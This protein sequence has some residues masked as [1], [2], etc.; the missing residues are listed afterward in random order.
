VQA[1]LQSIIGAARDDAVSRTGLSPSAVKVLRAERVT[2]PDGSLGCPSPGMLYTQALVPGFRVMLDAGGQA[3][4]Y[5][6]GASGQLLLCP[7][8]RAVEPR[9]DERI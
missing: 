2:W 8:G 5:H 9:T 4:D 6:A 1:D 3:L 7:P